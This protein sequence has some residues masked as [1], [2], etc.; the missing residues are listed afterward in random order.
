MSRRFRDHL[1]RSSS[2]SSSLP[3]PLLALLSCGRLVSFS[4]SFNLQGSIRP[5]IRLQLQLVPRKA[6]GSLPT[7]TSIPRSLIAGK[8]KSSPNN[9]LL[10]SSISKALRY[11]GTLRL[12]YSTLQII[13]I[14]TNFLAERSDLTDQPST[15][16][17]YTTLR[18]QAKK[19]ARRL[20]IAIRR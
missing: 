6:F 5:S 9:Q 14:T 4:F 12:R 13:E 18:T 7:T 20:P 16:D 10:F 1:P 19:A 8:V 2:R 3:L 17:Y 15:R 11:Y